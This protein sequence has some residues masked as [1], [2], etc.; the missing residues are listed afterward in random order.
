MKKD[1]DICWQISYILWTN[2]T[3]CHALRQVYK[4]LEFFFKKMKK[5]WIKS[6]EKN[7]NKNRDVNQYGSWK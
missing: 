5:V 4:S 1:V 3:K 2:V 6:Q 7:S